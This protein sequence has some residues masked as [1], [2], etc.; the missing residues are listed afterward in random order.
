MTASLETLVIAA[1]VFAHSLPIPRP[2]PQGKISD[3]ELIALAVAQ[4]SMGEPSDRKFLGMIAYRLEGWF[5]HL[6]DQSQYNRRLRRLAP[7][8]VI[9]Q[10]E[11]AQLIA[12]GD[13]RLADGTLISCANYAG[14]ASRSHFAGDA[15]YGFCPSKS[16]FYWGMRLVLLTDEM[17]VPLGYELVAPREGEREPL[18][19]LAQAHPGTVLF[20]DKGFWGAEYEQT[21]E[22]LAA[23]L[24]TPERHR[25]G[26][27]PPAEVAK[28]T[29]RLVI[30][31]VFANLKRQMRLEEHLAK[32]LGGLVQRVAQRLLALTLGI[33]I[34]AQ[35]GR[36]LRSLVAYDGR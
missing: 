12:S 4:A 27:R 8:I 16:R 2:G 1:Y 23:Q 34:N 14:C 21:I 32:T 11:L 28:A 33:F 15:G 18:F 5:A 20:A 24:I 6:P 31:S 19:R 13:T 29:I 3:A 10:L 25:L 36:P 26:E 35:L 7:H 30:E 22:L 17:G 9:V